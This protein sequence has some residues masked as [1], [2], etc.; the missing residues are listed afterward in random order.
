[1]CARYI[2]NVISWFVGHTRCA[3]FSFGLHYYYLA[4]A[5]PLI[6]VLSSTVC[7]T[8]S[9]FILGNR[10]STDESKYTIHYIIVAVKSLVMASGDIYLNEVRSTRRFIR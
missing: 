8:S 3:Q 5:M 6:R 1:M 9:T 4:E 2:I 10:S 7:D